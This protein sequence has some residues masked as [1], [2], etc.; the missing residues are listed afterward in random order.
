MIEERYGRSP[1]LSV[2]EDIRWFNALPETIRV[3]ALV[4]FIRERLES[5]REK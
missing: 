1:S 5:E 2:L 4:A 3:A